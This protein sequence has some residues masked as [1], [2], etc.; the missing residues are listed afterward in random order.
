MSPA[1]PSAREPSKLPLPGLA[2][3]ALL[4][5]FPVGY[6]ELCRRRLG[7]VFR[8]PYPGSPPFAFVADPQLARDLYGHDRE[9]GRAGEARAPFL[10]P[11]VGDASL[12]CL[13]GDAW[14]R[15][16]ELIAPA[17]HGD[18]V[19]RW[20]EAI[21]Q[22]TNAEMD[23]WQP[24][25]S[26]ALRPRMQAI[27]LEVILRLVFGVQDAGRLEQ[28]RAAVP[29]LLDR[30][31]VALL[32][33]GLRRRLEQPALTRLPGNPVRAFTRLRGEVD[34]LLYAEIARRRAEGRDRLQERD[35]LLSVLMASQDEDGEAMTDSELRD[36]LI[37]LLFA[38]HETTSTALAWTFER[39]VRYPDALRALRDDLAAG[40]SGYLDAVIKETLRA[41][42]VVFDTP[43]SLSQP[44]VL[45]DYLLPEGWLVAPAIPL[46]H[47]DAELFPDPDDFRPERFLTDSPPV[48]GWIPFGGGQRRCVGSR[49]AMLELQTIVAAVVTRFEL[50][51]TRPAA[52]RQRVRAVTLT[53]AN[54]ARVTLGRRLGGG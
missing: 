23:H 28:L 43:R 32:I 50:T 51:A 17:L 42:P 41:R 49:L 20:R 6:L 14:R 52:E 29:R 1:P 44:L 15:Q 33:P 53:P 25:Q 40:G 37:T 18:R 36:E 9:V 47:R 38:G 7:P 11:L 5:A 24:G 30:A 2:Q 21:G 39:L 27:T 48:A 26:F 45:G 4:A 10:T 22:I 12:L 8:V 13:E 54:G 34:A 46:V 31:S 3:M 16:R 35:D 19:V